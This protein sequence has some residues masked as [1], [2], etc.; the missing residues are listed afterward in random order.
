M[1]GFSECLVIPV[2]REPVAVRVG[3]AQVTEPRNQKP[4]ARMKRNAARI[5]TDLV[6]WQKS[7]Q[8]VLQIYKYTESFPN[9]EIY[10]LVS[11]LRRAAVSIPANIAEGFKRQGKMDK[12]RFLNLSQASAEECRYFLI[13]ANDLQ[14]GD[15]RAL[16]ESLEEISKLLEAYSNA[17]QNSLDSL[18]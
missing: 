6:V 14:Y 7:H 2:L 9:R 17:I 15:A 18:R 5:F 8:F 12:K 10:G 4:E 11:Q 13:L 16:M 3:I 1:L